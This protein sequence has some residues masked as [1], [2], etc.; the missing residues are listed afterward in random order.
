[1]AQGIISQLY[2]VL[3]VDRSTSTLATDDLEPNENGEAKNK[4]TDRLSTS[5]SNY[6]NFKIE[7]YF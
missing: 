5:R 7:K 1:M 6:V 2:L 4:L 3:L